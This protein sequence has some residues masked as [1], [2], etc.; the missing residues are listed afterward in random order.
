MSDDQPANRL[1]LTVS[2][3]IDAGLLGGWPAWYRAVEQEGLDRLIAWL[4]Q[5]LA[6]AIPEEELVELAEGIVDAPDAE[7]RALAAADLAELVEEDDPELADLLWEGVSAAGKEL[8]DAELLY[9]SAARQAAIAELFGDPLAA[10]EFFIDFLNWR[11]SDDSHAS[12]PELVFS[13]FDEIIRLAEADRNAT[14]AARF[15]HD[16]AT[17][18]RVVDSDDP[19]AY[20]G[21]WTPKATPFESWE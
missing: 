10:A 21:D 15:T 9:E 16:Q 11:R 17:F 6:E 18:G 7:S 2:P 3:R 4:K 1:V 13:A 19:A 20:Q 5:R 12:D 8:G 14:A